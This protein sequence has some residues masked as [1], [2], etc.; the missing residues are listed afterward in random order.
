MKIRIAV[1]DFSEVNVVISSGDEVDFVEFGFMIF[2]DDGV[3]A[4]C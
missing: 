2:G 1:F 4:V 3:A